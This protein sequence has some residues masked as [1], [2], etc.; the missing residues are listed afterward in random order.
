VWKWPQGAGV[1]GVT[2]HQK[3]LEIF[4]EKNLNHKLGTKNHFFEKKL[5]AIVYEGELSSTQCKQSSGRKEP[6]FV[7][8]EVFNR[9]SKL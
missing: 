2:R 8:L 1:A 4:F 9:K 7:C 3:Y 5:K 6:Y